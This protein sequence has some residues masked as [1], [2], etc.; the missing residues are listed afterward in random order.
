MDWKKNLSQN[1]KQ[2]VQHIESN[3]VE[4]IMKFEDG[5]IEQSDLLLFFTVLINSKRVWS[6]QGIYI[7][8]AVQ[9]IGKNILELKFDTPNYSNAISKLSTIQKLLIR[10]ASDEAITK[11]KRDKLTEEEIVFLIQ[12]LQK[13]NNRILENDAIAMDAIV[14][15]L[16]NEYFYVVQNLAPRGGQL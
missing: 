7:R 6:L 1:E 10:M 3:L 2:Q 5:E 13:S 11:W 14:H 12:Y 8:I 4:Y 16:R 9:L 15:G